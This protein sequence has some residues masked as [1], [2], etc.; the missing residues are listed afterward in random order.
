MIFINPEKFKRKKIIYSKTLSPKIINNISNN[1]KNC[2]IKY[3]ANNINNLN[4][5]DDIKNNNEKYK[6]KSL[7]SFNSSID[8]NSLLFF[9]FKII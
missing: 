8:S 2:L 6:E 7:H 1:I 4:S 9:K 5:N 3:N